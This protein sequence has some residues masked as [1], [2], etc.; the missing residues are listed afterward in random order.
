MKRALRAVGVGMRGMDEPFA[1]G[2][3]ERSVTE[4]VVGK[5]GGMDEPW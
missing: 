5:I 1:S 3:V 4:L 2:G